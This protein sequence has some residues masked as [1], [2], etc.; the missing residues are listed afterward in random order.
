MTE[1]QPELEEREAR[2]KMV[3]MAAE[4]AATAATPREGSAWEAEWGMETIPG[5][6]A[7]T[8]HLPIKVTEASVSD[9]EADG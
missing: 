2:K 4:A 9:T 3:P 8:D 1:Q 5:C 7:S 6:E